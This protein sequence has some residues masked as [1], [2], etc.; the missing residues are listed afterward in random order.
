MVAKVV[1]NSLFS[2]NIYLTIDL[3]KSNGIGT[4]MGVVST[5]GV[6]G[7]VETVGNHYAKVLP[8]VNGNLGLIAVSI[9][10]RVGWH[11]SGTA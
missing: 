3:G 11:W 5:E 1:G 4:N 6:V 8:I 7:V 9:G 10:E 2:K